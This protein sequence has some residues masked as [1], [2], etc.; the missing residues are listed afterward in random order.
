MAYLIFARHRGLTLATREDQDLIHGMNFV[1]N[2]PADGDFHG[3]QL[4]VQAGVEDF[5]ELPKSSNLR[6]ELWKV[7]HFVLGRGGGHLGIFT[8][9]Y[10]RRGE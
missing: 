6:G 9:A 7:H 4:A 1:T 8:V 2:V 5:A 3:H 10:G